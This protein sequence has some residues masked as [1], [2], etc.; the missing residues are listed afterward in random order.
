M[1]RVYEA[2]NETLKELFVGMTE[3]TLDQV[4][5]RHQNG[6]PAS[7]AHWK[8]GAQ[9]IR[10]REVEPDLPD[11]KA[12]IDGYARTMQKSGWKSITE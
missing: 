3:L 8:L 9:R 1:P 12:F 4:Q 10:Y 2:I 5:A 11:A 7:I 6:L